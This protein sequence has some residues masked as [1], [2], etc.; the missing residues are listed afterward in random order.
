M[1]AP[2]GVSA[3]PA[4]ARERRHLSLLIAAGIALLGL[5]GALIVLY[6]NVP[7]GYDVPFGLSLPS[8]PLF[9]RLWRYPALALS[10][11][12]FPALAALVM[13]GLW[14]VY[15][16]G[17]VVVQRCLLGPQRR[18]IAC[19]VAVFAG[20]FVILLVTV[21][22]PV[23][24]SDIYQYAM[25]GRL[26]AVYHVNPYVVAPSAFS[27]DE[28]FPFLF[29]LWSN[30][31]TPYGPAWTLMSAVTAGA[32]GQSALATIIAFKAM[33]GL[34]HLANCALVFLLARQVTGRDGIVALLL[35]AWNPLILLETVGS[36]H[37]EAVM[38]TFALAGLLLITNDKVL[39]GVALLVVSVLVKYLTGIL[40]LL[41]TLVALS[42][43]KT[44]V[45]ALGL[46]GRM[47]LV[48]AAV[49]ALFYAPFL[50]GVHSLGQLL[51]LGTSLAPLVV[52]PLHQILFA[53]VR[54]LG[55]GLPAVQSLTRSDVAV[56][57]NS[58]FLLIFVVV[59][60]RLLKNRAS[61][62]QVVN[63]W[64]ILSFVYIV[65]VF[66]GGF[67]WYM[68]SLL[69][70]FLVGS[71]RKSNRLLFFTCA[72]IGFFLMLLGYAVL[73]PIV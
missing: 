3:V 46:A 23:L 44:V 59:V 17:A 65:F 39:L 20:L 36:G 31:S 70:I 8:V 51:G 54:A 48:A 58:V 38:M 45:A 19:L 15:A 24:S 62:P 7:A 13:I 41:V 29:A 34:F 26:A 33:A 67:P 52:N 9:A 63:A 32:A 16:F 18:T 28:L 27:Q 50:G 25:N 56:A 47:V 4:L 30:M 6:T 71:D 22:P 61:W 2:A 14:G 42:R 49:A 10:L 69:P 5:Y 1:T 37:N 57:L 21:A 40:L 72:S 73:R 12:L 60:V 43:Q 66:G 55:R 11:G 35:Y 53:V 68:V 64:G